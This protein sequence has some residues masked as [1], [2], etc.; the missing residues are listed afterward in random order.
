M[1]VPGKSKQQIR[2]RVP[3]RQ[4]RGSGGGDWGRRSRTCGNDGEVEAGDAAPA[5]SGGLSCRPF[6]RSVW[7]RDGVEVRREKGGGLP[8]MQEHEEEGRTQHTCGGD[9]VGGGEGDHRRRRRP[10]SVALPRFP[11]SPR[12]FF[13]RSEAVRWGGARSIQRKTEVGGSELW[14]GW[15]QCSRMPAVFVCN[16]VR[17][18]RTL[19]N[20]CIGGWLMPI[21]N[22]S[23]Q[24][25][26]LNGGL[27]VLQN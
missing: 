23:P 11:L 13:S 7:E 18:C 8:E 17:Q 3:I 1:K 9:G 20:S 27:F 2:V 21:P 14:A 5:G 16:S 12:S 15:R 25:Q 24:C 4:I 26:L 6:S 22:S 19:P 10:P